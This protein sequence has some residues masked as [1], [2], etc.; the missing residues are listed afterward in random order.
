MLWVKAIHLVFVVTWFAGLF[1]LP[2]LFVYHL[3]CEETAGRE[4]FKLMEHKLFFIIMTPGAI[5]AVALGLWML[6]DN[7]AIYRSQGWVHAKL[8]LVALLAGFHFL[9]G[10]WLYAFKRDAPPH[11]EKFFRIANEFPTLVLVATMIVAVV[12]PF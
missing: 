2:R 11:S 12:K 6:V 9:C 5:A 3:G 10:R 7:W 4:R 8:G 1:Y